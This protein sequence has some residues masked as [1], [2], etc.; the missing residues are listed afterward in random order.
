MPA[1]LGQHFLK[2]KNV[3]QDIARS[4]N[5]EDNDGVIEIGPGHGEL[6]EFIL[7]EI[8]KKENSKLML[9]EK[10]IKLYKKLLDAFSLRG[11]IELIHHD[12]LKFIPKL[13][14]NH[15]LQFTNYKIVGNIPYY[16]TGKLL[17]IIS[18]LDPLPKKIVLLIQKEVA[19]RVCATPP[20][21]NLLAASVQVWAEPK[22]LFHVPRHDF[23]PPPDVES[24]VIILNS[25]SSPQLPA[26][27]YYKFIKTLF[28]QPRKTIMNNLSLE[29]PK[30]QIT[31]ALKT[32]K[33]PLEA[34]PQN[35]S[36][37]Q[38]ASL[39]QVFIKKQ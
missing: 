12:A 36:M 2:N 9:I 32:F 11:N 16:I 22:I 1:R 37:N 19:E 39:S 3:L 38:I 18:E 35:L 24:A 7:K 33:I 30:E 13:F 23:S 6:T 26:P 4:L 14:T 5:V 27:S 34:R 25:A 10:D 17:R 31:S 15:Q 28:K 29:H 21:M 8:S 20:H